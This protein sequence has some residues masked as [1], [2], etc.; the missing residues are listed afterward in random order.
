[1]VDIDGIGPIPWFGVS[2]TVITQ[3]IPVSFDSVAG[4]AGYPCP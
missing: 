4:E 3:V 1:M 2:S